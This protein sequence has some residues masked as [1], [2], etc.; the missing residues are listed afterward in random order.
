MD[1]VV[2]NFLLSCTFIFFCPHL[3]ILNHTYSGML[4]A[5]LISDS[6]WKI[7]DWLF[8]FDASMYK[9]Y[10]TKETII[11]EIFILLKFITSAG[12]ALHISSLPYQ[13]CY[14]IYVIIFYRQ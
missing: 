4:F 2:Q 11:I 7:S 1:G 14:K 6:L 13:L 12:A 3:K 5:A 9:I 8:I 10:L